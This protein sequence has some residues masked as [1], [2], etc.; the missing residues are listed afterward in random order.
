[1]ITQNP[2]IVNRIVNKKGA[3]REMI[4]Y[5][6]CLLLMEE[7]F[8]LVFGLTSHIDSELSE[9]AVV[10]LRKND[11]GMC[12]AAAKGGKM[13]YCLSRNGIK[14]CAYRKGYKHLIRV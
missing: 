7:L 12:L 14:S 11:A 9:N 5:G 6:G 8:G 13:L 3:A 1:M 10:R 2:F 4:S